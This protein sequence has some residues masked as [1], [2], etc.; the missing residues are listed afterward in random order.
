MASGTSNVSFDRMHKEAPIHTAVEPETEAC[1]RELVQIAE[2]P[3]TTP[4]KRTAAKAGLKR[5]TLRERS[6]P[7]LRLLEVSCQRL[8]CDAQCALATIMGQTAIFTMQ[9]PIENPPHSLDDCTDETAAS[10]AVRR[11]V[12]PHQALS[13]RNTPDHQAHPTSGLQIPSAP[14]GAVGN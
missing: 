3:H 14:S 4:E 11:A 1:L 2:D 12:W 5:A 13:T 9:S 8:G 7:E 10:I 6:L